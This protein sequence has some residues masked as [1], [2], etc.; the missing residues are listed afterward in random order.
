MKLSILDV[1]PV[2]SGSSAAAALGRAADLAR[3]ADEHGYTRLWFAEHHGDRG[4]RN[5]P[6]ANEGICLDVRV[7]AEGRERIR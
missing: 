6:C 2:P 4:R 1:L 3:L 7:G 5:T